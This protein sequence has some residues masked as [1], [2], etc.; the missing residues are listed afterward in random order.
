MDSIKLEDL[1]IDSSSDEDQLKQLN[2]SQNSSFGSQRGGRRNN[3]RRNN[4]V[5]K[6]ITGTSALLE[7]HEDFEKLYFDIEVIVTSNNEEAR[8]FNAKS[9][10]NLS[11][12][13][14]QALRYLEFKKLLPVQASVAPYLSYF[15]YH[16][17]IIKAPAGSGKTF[18]YIVPI[19]DEIQRIKMAKRDTRPNSTAPYAVVVAPSRELV[20]QLYNMTQH[21]VNGYGGYVR[22]AYGFG[23]QDMK[24]SKVTIEDGCDIIFL[25]LGRLQ[26]Y[27]MGKG[28]GLGLENLRYIVIDEA[29]NFMA[30]GDRHLMEQAAIEE[31]VKLAV[32]RSPDS[33]LLQ[34]ILVGAAV[35]IEKALKLKIVRNNCI[36][37]DVR[38]K[39]ASNVV[40]EVVEVP[41]PEDRTK[42]LLKYLSNYLHHPQDTKKVIV[43]VNGIQ[44]SVR[45]QSMLVHYGFLAGVVS[46]K[47]MQPEREVDIDKFN[48][49]TYNVLVVTDVMASGINLAVDCVVMYELPKREEFERSMLNRTGRTGRL[50]QKGR[51]VYLYNENEDG[52]YAN[53]KLLENQCPVP[54]FLDPD[55]S[56]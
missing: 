8:S 5:Y 16:D 10:Y 11:S 40:H 14:A 19:C 3:N 15:C 49:G 56:I 1:V 45:I 38:T 30:Y 28:F 44:E 33:S 4:K 29:D 25:T 32:K 23:R 53:R 46:S 35:D 51:V 20:K 47:R 50:G 42:I 52:F 43:S 54:S 12:N 21:F 48:K 26:H 6:D 9:G 37:L 17:F 31:F 34:T 7:P 55:E 41:N 24:T 13:T 39:H 22:C 27:F 18:A 36:A 2:T